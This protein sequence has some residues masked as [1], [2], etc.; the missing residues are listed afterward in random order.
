MNKC[1]TPAKRRER[2]MNLNFFFKTI[3]M[4][5]TRICGKISDKKLKLQGN[6]DYFSSNHQLG[7]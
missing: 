7:I 4:K 3:K 2:E 1:L 6:L 5:R